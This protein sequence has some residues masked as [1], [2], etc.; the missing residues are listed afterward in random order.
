[1]LTAVDVQSFEDAIE[2]AL[3]QG[4]L[5]RA[6]RIAELYRRVAGPADHQAEPAH[7]PWFRAAYLGGQVLL[8]AG[9]LG[10]A[11]ARFRPLLAVIARL[12]ELL[13]QRL[14]LLAAEALAR[15]NRPAEARALLEQVSES[16]LAG[17]LLL[18]L[19]ALRIRLWLG[20]VRQL[21]AELTACNRLLEAQ[22]ETAN[23]A[24][25]ACEEGRAWE[26]CGD[27]SR[28][29]QCW[30]RAEMLSATLDHDPIRAD[31]LLQLGRFDHLRGHLA[32]ALDRY[33]QALQRARAGGQA[34][35][36]Q[37]RR[38]LVTFDINH[39]KQARAAADEVLGDLTSDDLPEEIRPLLAMVRAV[40]DGRELPDSSVEL[41]AYQAASRGEIAAA[42]ALYRE[43]LAAAA[44]P[45][46]QARLAL[47]LG[48]LALGQAE[49]HEALSWLRQAEELARALDLPEVLARALQAR[50]QVLAE[51]DGDAESA[52]PL[53]EDAV[54]MTE[55]QAGQFRHASDATF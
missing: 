26:R 2:K 8:T 55:V 13:G 14:R 38:L 37:L 3:A 18:R 1:M 50:G 17:Q 22:G 32:S 24:L 27:G 6:E 7:A 47:A 19:R 49:R 23:R 30:R 21:D 15:L 44:A 51:L 20:E 54:V 12:P 28:A 11:L 41:R 42:Q 5:D 35:E 43:A 46:R 34:L 9:K 29:E 39:G 48:L 40:L 4:E 25:L 36:I 31:L 10:Q 45:H 52:R 53:F 16:V 33:D